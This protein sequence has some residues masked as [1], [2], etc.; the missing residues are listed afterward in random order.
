M[1]L[2]TYITCVCLRESMYLLRLENKPL[3]LKVRI[4]LLITRLKVVKNVITFISTDNQGAEF[5][6]LFSHLSK[7]L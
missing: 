1:G 5:F 7:A 2:N 6:I 4:L 3:H